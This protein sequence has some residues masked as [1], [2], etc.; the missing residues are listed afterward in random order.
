MEGSGDATGAR[1]SPTR[2]SP[3]SSADPLESFLEPQL[4]RS[5]GA[6]VSGLFE[7]FEVVD[8]RAEQ[9]HRPPA[10][11]GLLQQCDRSPHD[12]VRIAGSLVRMTARDR[13][14]VA[15]ADLDRHG[16]RD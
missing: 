15:V 9:S 8:A 2:S 4:R 7:W 1:S 13:G 3:Q 14:E 10:V 5:G 16:A 6:R 12:L 11:L